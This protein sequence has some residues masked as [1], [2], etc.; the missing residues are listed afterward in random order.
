MSKGAA[1][2]PCLAPL[3]AEPNRDPA[4]EAQMWLGESQALYYKAQYRRVDL[5]I[6]GSSLRTGTQPL[7]ELP[8]QMLFI[9]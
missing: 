5:K 3:S 1:S 2:L 6:R 9:P 8:S 4:S 7:K